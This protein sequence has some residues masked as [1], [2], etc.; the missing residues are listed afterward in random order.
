MSKNRLQKVVELLADYGQMIAY[1]TYHTWDKGRINAVEMVSTK[2]LLTD[3]LCDLI[4]EVTNAKDLIKNQVDIYVNAAD[5]HVKKEITLANNRLKTMIK[6]EME[7]LESVFP[8]IFADKLEKAL[9][10]KFEGLNYR[11]MQLEDGMKKIK[12]S[13]TVIKPNLH[14]K[15][16]K[17]SKLKIR[18]V[19]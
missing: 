12:S 6:E 9:L 13:M 17:K 4:D 16:H 3:D 11:L 14:I 1:N 8:A 15:S 5:I 19:K 2:K 7:H 10:A 18:A